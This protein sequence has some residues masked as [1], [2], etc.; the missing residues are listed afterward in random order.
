MRAELVRG[1]ESKVSMSYFGS[2]Q[3]EALDQPE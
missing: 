1:R 3:K 2:G